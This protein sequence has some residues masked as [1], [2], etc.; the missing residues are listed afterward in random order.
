[1]AISVFPAAGGEF[2][3]NDF[4]V[5]M[6]NT[7]NNVIDLGRAYAAGAY[8]ITLASGD[9]TFDIYALDADGNSV[10]YTNNATLVTSAEFTTLVILGVSDSEKITFSFAGAS[11]NATSEGDAT[12]AGAYL[13]NASPTDLPTQD[14]TTTVTGGNFASDVQIFFESGATSTEAKNITRNDST[15]LIVT[16][17]DALDAGLDPWSLRVVNP[18]VTEPTGSDAHILFDVIEAGALPV[19]Q[20]TS[21]LPAANLN[22]AYSE[23]IEASDADGDVTFS[24]ITGSLPTGLTLDSSTGVISGTPTSGEETFTVQV[25]DN[26]GNTNTREFV[27]PVNVATGGVITT[28]GN[29]TFHTFNSSDDFQ[30]FA[31]KTIEWAVIAGGGGGGGKG[32]SVGSGGGA[33][34]VRVSFV[35]QTETPGSNGTVESAT[36]LSPGTYTVTVGAG[37]NAAAVSGGV[38]SQDSNKG[39]DSSFHTISSAGGGAGRGLNSNP[40]GGS[41]AG[42]TGDPPGTGIATQ[43]FDG[44]NTNADNQAGGGGGGATSVGGT[45]TDPNV[46]ALG[47]SGIEIDGLTGEF[48]IGG[49]GGTTEISTPTSP[50]NAGSGGAAHRA[51]SDATGNAGQNGLVVLRYE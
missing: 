36:A 21:P 40:N 23:T 43:G 14:D 41:G 5:D 13:E 27:L 33:G 38:I 50:Q 42:A 35:G 22:E 26:G 44:G 39:S 37:G 12:N 2:V 20:T 16:R 11:N 9:S 29:Y 30:L 28:E 45:G 25:E 31:N 3:T 10:A 1:M 48:A 7:S 51:I 4:V 8:D 17:P 15:E 18:G 24:I 6:N 32:T 49:Q 34:G 47:G 46:I 19:F